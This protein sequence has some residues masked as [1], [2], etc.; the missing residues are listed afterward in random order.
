MANCNI[1][2]GTL[3]Q[4]PRPQGTASSKSAPENADQ[5]FNGAST[6]KLSP[7]FVVPECKAIKICTYGLGDNDF[8]RIHKVVPEG[9]VFPQSGGCLCLCEDG[10]PGKVALSEPLRID[11]DDVTLTG[12]TNVTF[13]TIPNTYQ[14][15]LGDETLIGKVTVIVQ[16]V[17]CCCLPQ[18]LVIGN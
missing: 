17:D 6:S 5:L 16:E 8:I 3:I 15:E 13:L 7:M 10:K 12:C 2:T 18:R 14:L 11:C 4:K 9:G 1:S